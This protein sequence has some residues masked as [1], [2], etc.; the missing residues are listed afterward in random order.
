MYSKFVQRFQDIQCTLL[1][2]E[3]EYNADKARRKTF[4]ILAKCGHERTVNYYDFIRRGLFLC[5]DCINNRDD[6]RVIPYSE[7]IRRFE[8]LGCKIITPEEEYLAFPKQMNLFKFTF[9]ARCGHERTS[10]YNVMAE[11]KLGLCIDCTRKA[12]SKARSIIMATPF[13][14]MKDKFA[15][16]GAQLLTKKD[17]DQFRIVATCGHETTVRYNDFKDSISKACI[18]CARKLKGHGNLEYKKIKQRFTDAGC[19]LLVSEGEF[20]SNA[21]TTSSEFLFKASCGHERSIIFNNSKLTPNALCKDCSKEVERVKSQQKAKNEDGIAS[22]LVI[23]QNAIVYLQEIIGNEIDTYICSEGCKADILV[24]PR[25]VTDDLWM[26]V[27]IK[28]T[29]GKVNNKYRF[30]IEGKDYRDLILLCICAIEKKMWV[31][32]PSKVINKQVIVVTDKPGCL[33]YEDKVDTSNL[34]K[35]LQKR[36]K[37]LPLKNKSEHQVTNSH[38]INQEQ[39]FADLR[40]QKLP[41]LPFERPHMNYLVY[42]FLV[43][44][45]KV[46]EK[47]ISDNNRTNIKKSCGKNKKQPYT[48]GDNDFYWFVDKDEKTFYVV[49]EAILIVKGYISTDTQPGIMR[50]SSTGWLQDF[51]YSYEEKDHNRLKS[52]FNV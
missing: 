3:K 35:L 47:V 34:V 16:L 45:Y 37:S 51:K 46:Q 26:P 14:E 50:F 48:Q 13:D 18:D 30:S 38:T 52:L 9:T 6:E 28:S 42:D 33:Y 49:P 8:E 29:R 20:I 19:E 36:Y 40:R 22:T 1:T 43:N 17:K 10:T 2:T 12:T 23:E 15:L 24:K 21:M 41:F 5:N 44:G 39:Y 31:I 4:R 11:T 27:Q 25:S 7:Y 32:D